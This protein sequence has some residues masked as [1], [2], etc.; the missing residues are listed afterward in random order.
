MGDWIRERDTRYTWLGDHVQQLPSALLWFDRLITEYKISSV[1]ELGTG[2]GTLTCLFGMRCPGAVVTVDIEDRRRPAT[3]DLF[4]AL[5]IVRLGIDLSDG[6]TI[7][8]L[9][10]KARAHRVPGEPMLLFVDSGDSEKEREF[11]A[12]TNPENG[13]LESGDLVAVHDCGSQFFPD[14]PA[15]VKAAR[16]GRLRRILSAELDADKTRLAVYQVG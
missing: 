5:D 1:L 4:S 10:D 13:L 7:E 12:Y 14:S 9:A 3:K 2:V 16:V 15:N 6:G 8:R 11:A